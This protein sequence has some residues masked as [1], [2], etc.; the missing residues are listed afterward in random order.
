MSGIEIRFCLP[1]IQEI[2][3]CF[4]TSKP[5]GRSGRVAEQSRGKERESTAL[6]DA[7]TPMPS[8]CGCAT[9]THFDKTRS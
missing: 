1:L 6:R 3:V 7:G 9:L 8:A 4:T 2:H 5:V